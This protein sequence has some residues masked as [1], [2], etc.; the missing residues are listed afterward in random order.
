[1]KKSLF[2][3]CGI[4]CLLPA[5]CRS[6]PDG[7]VL[8]PEAEEVSAYAPEEDSMNAYMEEAF[9]REK[10]RFQTETEYAPEDPDLLL[11]QT[12]D[13]YLL[14]IHLLLADPAAEPFEVDDPLVRSMLAY[15]SS[16]FSLEALLTAGWRYELARS[17]GVT[18]TLLGHR[19]EYKSIDHGGE[20]TTVQVLDA[21]EI[22]FF[23][24]DFTSGSGDTHILR[25]K[26]EKGEWKI[27]Y[28]FPGDM[29]KHIHENYRRYLEKC[30]Y[31]EREKIIGWMQENWWGR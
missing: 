24:N 30:P 9:A 13:G 26:Q 21:A 12:V 22:R 7:A 25:L 20:E 19:T 18:Y 17:N 4:L 23:D 1:M 6:V 2:F 14:S 11:K 27:T 31:T 28:D 29:M 8:S 16:D 5:A 15:C 3:L 10:E